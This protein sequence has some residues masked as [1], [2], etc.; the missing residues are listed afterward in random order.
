MVAPT[1]MLLGAAL[2]VTRHGQTLHNEL[3]RQALRSR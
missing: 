3:T 1:A 2:S